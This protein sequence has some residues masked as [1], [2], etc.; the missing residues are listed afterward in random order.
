MTIGNGFLLQSV[1][2][3]TAWYPGGK[4]RNPSGFVVS[5]HLFLL[6][7]QKK[8]MIFFSKD[9]QSKVKTKTVT[10][11]ELSKYLLTNLTVFEIADELSDYILKE[12][13]EA[14]PI[15]VTEEEFE[16]ICSMFRVKGKRMVDGCYVAETRGRRPVTNKND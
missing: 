9:M 12:T 2:K 16:R 1:E 6:S 10:K 14:Q 5:T 4:K 15:A 13:P 8:K 3:H 11:E 7:L